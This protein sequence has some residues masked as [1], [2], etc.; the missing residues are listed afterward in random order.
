MA[1]I[2]MVSTTQ[3][4]FHVQSAKIPV[5][6]NLLMLFL[7][8]INI[9]F[10]LVILVLVGRNLVKLY[11]ESKRKVF[12]SR[13]QTR[14]VFSFVTFTLIPSILLFIVASGLITNAIDNW[15]SDTVEKSL[16][17]SLEVAE[18][19]Y[20]SSEEAV[21]VQASKFAQLIKD[22]RM[23]AEKNRIYLK[24]SVNRHLKEF[25]VEQIIVYDAD[26]KEL[27]RDVAPGIKPRKPKRIDAKGM[28]RLEKGETIT[29]IQM[30]AGSS[31][32]FSM[33][34][35][36]ASGKD[37]RRLAG[38]VFLAD[39]IDKPVV[40]KINTITKT[41]EDY[42]QLKLQKFPIKAVYEVTLLLVAL[43][44][45]FAAVWY[46]LYL[47]K[48]ITVPISKL[49]EATQRVTSGDLSVRLEAKTVDEIGFLINSF[50]RMT[51]ELE[52]SRS[53]LESSHKELVAT[54]LELDR[55][56]QYIET[57]FAKI[58]TG[59]ISIDNR[60]RITMFN[61][62]AKSILKTKVREPLGK[63]Y[64]DVFDPVHL[65]PIR[66]IMR[67][68]GQTQK[69]SLEREVKVVIDDVQLT[70][71]VHITTLRD[72]GGRFLGLAVV[73]D[74]LTAM[75]NAQK[76]SAW[77]DIA[78]HI[79]HEIKNPLTPIQLN[80]DRLIRQFEVDR[81]NF[82]RIFKDS[83][84]QIIKEVDVIST[85]VDEFRRFAQLPEAKPELT[86]LNTIISDVVGM[87]KD[88]K[89]DIRIKTDMDSSIGPVRLDP[90]QMHR[91]FRNLIEN[92]IDAVGE[93]GTIEIKSSLD[94]EKKRILIEIIDNGSGIDAKNMD[95]VFL[96]YFSTKTKGSGLGLA[97]VN[98]IVADHEGHIR[99]KNRSP[100]G[101][102]MA[103]DLPA[104]A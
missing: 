86:S 74:D 71:L 60:G 93:K 24:N 85:L 104:E 76:T 91:V 35:I 59:V 95:K 63:Y 50:N 43:I 51:E 21:S 58:A 11:S 100:Q 89:Q 23:L 32:V 69:E 8:N 17:D 13:F 30:T 49:A 88:L 7:L 62:A 41:F 27:A 48:D 1:M 26:F 5:A 19:L 84:K 20:R 42:K 53:K 28:D 15:F 14:L 12:G 67:E 45:L 47:A 83:T 82:N 99:V 66:A 90:E 103:I 64:D 34:P 39:S 68:M 44:I 33:A 78:Q 37:N 38:T 46:G 70:L 72:A 54:N 52:T 61:P 87:Y 57:I 36:I 98:R 10:L 79:A 16:K 2:V 40:A 29:N 65:E 94:S 77:R 55:R 75:L 73:F 18:T 3:M 80:T 56:R 101:T 9:I 31:R 81:E 25:G 97:I 102:I 6:H 4:L 96:P 22:K 92:A